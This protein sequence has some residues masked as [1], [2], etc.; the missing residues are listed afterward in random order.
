MKKIDEKLPKTLV[1]IIG[2]ADFHK[3][4]VGHSGSG[5]YQILGGNFDHAYLKISSAKSLQMEK[6][7]LEWLENKLPVPKVY[8]YETIAETDYIVMSEIPGFHLASRT[9]LSNPDTLV[10]L[11]AD[12]LKMI[13]SLPIEQCPFDQRVEVKI[14]EAKARMNAELVNTDHFEEE[15]QGYSPEELLLL[16]EHTK[17]CEE[18]LVFTH[19][20]YCLPN[21]LCQDEEISGFIDMGSA[22]ISDRYQ[23]IALAVR[24]LKHNGLAD[25]IEKFLTRYGVRELD[26]KKLKFYILLDEF[27]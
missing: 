25:W 24:S 3:N 1:E 11:Y 8:Y 14:A 17:P 22:G 20:D 10:R 2:N 26:E 15:Y 9:M 5:V 18:D 21:I 16:L 13:H 12:G 7:I 4:T 6:L 23:D 19:G 27:F